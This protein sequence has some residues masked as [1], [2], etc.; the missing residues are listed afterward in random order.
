M[1]SMNDFKYY[2]MEI[3]PNS[4]LESKMVIVP[5]EWITFDDKRKCTV[6]KYQMPPFENQEDELLFNQLLESR[7]LPP[8]S[9]PSY[10]VFNRGEA[11][12]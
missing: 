11:S 1:D 6:A 8:E 9:W 4:E 10:P 3:T 7:M 12:K 2:L 5:I